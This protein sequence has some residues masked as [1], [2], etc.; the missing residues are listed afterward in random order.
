MEFFRMA[1][2]GSMDRALS[3]G[4]PDRI[5]LSPHPQSAVDIIDSNDVLDAGLG[6]NP[7][8]TAAA[9]AADDDLD[10]TICTWKASVCIAENSTEEP[11]SRAREEKRISESVGKFSWFADAELLIH[12]KCAL[13]HVLWHLHV[14]IEC[15]EKRLNQITTK[16]E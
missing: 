6:S 10:G 7:N 16:G 12:V 5:T 15:D 11:P 8:T 2:L 13:H 4:F 3:E 14:H 9:T 1:C